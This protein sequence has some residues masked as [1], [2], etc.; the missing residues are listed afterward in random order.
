MAPMAEPE[1]LAFDDAYRR[2]FPLIL[3]KC[4]RM[5]SDA[6]ESQDLVQF[7]AGYTHRIA[8]LVTL[9]L[10]VGIAGNAVAS[11]DL[12]TLGWRELSFDPLVAL[13]ALQRRGLLPQPLIR[14][15][16]S[17]TMALD[18]YAAVAYQLA[19]RTITESYL[20][21]ASWAW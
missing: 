4:R 18:V 8:D 15:D 16:V 6:V 19:T 21:G 12:P 9:S 13:G 2:V 3:S 17:E 14:V 11:G 1:H 5:I 10:A 20:G 7:T